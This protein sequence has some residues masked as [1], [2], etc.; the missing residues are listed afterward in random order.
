M[1]FSPTY[2]FHGNA[3]H[4]VR[5]G[6]AA[7]AGGG[8][9]VVARGLC[10]YFRLD[11][12]GIPALKRHA[13]LQLQLP[14]DAV[15][16]QTGYFASE[17]GDF[18]HVWVWNQALVD[19]AIA[20]LQ[21]G[22]SRWRLVPESACYAYP[23]HGTQ[24]SLCARPAQGARA[25]LVPDSAGYEGFVWNAQRSG[26]LGRKGALLDNQWWPQR[27]SAAQWLEFAQQNH[28]PGN[29]GVAAPAQLAS[30]RPQ[31]RPLAS[32]WVRQGEV[33]VGARSGAQAA[34]AGVPWALMGLGLAAAALCFY[35]G[36][37]LRQWDA[38]EV[39]QEQLQAKTASATDSAATRRMESARK[40]QETAGSANAWA[41]SAARYFASPD[42]MALWV[43]LAGPLSRQ[44][45]MIR[46]F[47]YRAG[48]LRFLLIAPRGNMDLPAVLGVFEAS[49]QL[50]DI[51][52][53]PT[54]DLTQ[55]RMKAKFRKPAMLLGKVQEG[56]L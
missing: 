52:I 48:E 54:Q 8:T 53:E 43:Y 2:L 37:L 27:P 17:Q 26:W 6:L 22:P 10:T 39:T 56:K 46:E 7:W 50:T 21:G 11:A 49:A 29:A 32:G 55:L 9:L 45:I 19:S 28:V 18:L 14:Q 24:L 36:A 13:F 41:M 40:A 47:D 20:Q 30:L 3:L 4:L 16:A 35:A 12:K 38:L 51:G 1:S 25:S 44:N 5:P 42:V 33:A 34:L 23:Q 31:M 15:Y